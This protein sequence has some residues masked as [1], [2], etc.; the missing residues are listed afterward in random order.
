MFEAAEGGAGVLR[1]L[2]TEHDPHPP[3]RPT[4]HRP[5]ALRPRHR[6][7]PGQSRARHRSLRPGLLR[8]PAV[9]RQPVG[10]PTPRPALRHR[11]AAD[12]D[13]RSTLEVAGAG[14][15]DRSEL[16]ARLE[17]ASNALETQ[18][19]RFL[20]DRGLPATR[21][22]PGDR[23]G[24]LRPPRFRLPHPGRRTSRSSS[25]APSTTPGTRQRRTNGPAPNSRTKPAGWCCGST[26]K[27][28]QP[29]VRPAPQLASH[30]R[31]EPRHLRP[32][33]DHLMTQ[34]TIPARHPGHRPRPGMAGAARLPAR[35]AARPPTRRPRRR[36][37]RAAARIWTTH[38]AA[39]F[40]APSVDDRGDAA[41]ARLLR[42]AL[43]LSFR[44]TAGPF[45]SFAQLSVSPRNY[46]LV[47]LMMAA[48]QDT[49]RLL[50]A[51]GV[52]VGKTIEAGLIAAE[53]LASG[54]AQRL[55]VLCSPQLAPQWQSELRTKFGINAAAAAA[56]H[57]Q[58]ARPDGAVRIH[59]LRALPV[60]DR[61]HRLHQATQP[62]RR[63]RPAVPRTGH[64]RRGPHLH[65]PDQE[66]APPRRTS[67]TH[68]C[69]GWPTTRPGT[70]CC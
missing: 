8:L 62:P 5:A 4:R 41:R 56:V 28:T 17:K 32:R 52:G 31:A 44:A 19:L 18:F 43:R 51:D 25:T 47:P 49:T 23:R 29:D 34:P 16:L 22:R 50:I 69:A 48:A 59:R 2:A 63:I 26:T 33:Q 27:T 66:S 54:D 70:C 24:L 67:D 7:R 13:A 53:L 58:P 68:C 38:A 12:H 37:H 15:E 36:N 64:R 1:R 11:P 35:D 40:D 65:R 14:G 30:R 57:R 3:R 20:D 55:A 60:P 61:L 21:R 42:D 9:L 39:V 46:Q 6:R 45:R 10:P